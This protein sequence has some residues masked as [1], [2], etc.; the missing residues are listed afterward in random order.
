MTYKTKNTVF[1]FALATLLMVMPLAGSNAFA[2]TG[3]NGEINGSCGIEEPSSINLGSVTSGAQPGHVRIDVI[4]DASIVGTFEI[5]S[6]TDWVGDGAKATG[7][8]LIL[9]S[10][11][12]ATITINNQPLLGGSGT[13]GVGEFDSDGTL[14][15]QATQIAT[16][17]NADTQ[18]I[19][20]VFGTGIEVTAFASG[21]AVLLTAKVAGTGPNAI[22]VV[23]S[24]E[25]VINV[26]D[27]SN[28]MIDGAT[29]ATHYLAEDVHYDIVTDGTAD[30]ADTY[31]TKAELGAIS[32]NVVLTTTTDPDEDNDIQ[33]YFHFSGVNTDATGT[34]TLVAVA[35][36]EQ[37]I[38]GGQTY[39]AEDDG[40]ALAV[41]EFAT[42]AT[43]GDDNNQ[44]AT[45]LAAAINAIVNNPEV[46]ASAGTNVVTI[47]AVKAGFSGNALAFSEAE[48]T[49][50]LDQAG[51]FL[52]G[53]DEKLINLPYSGALSATLT[54]GTACDSS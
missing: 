22:T 17:I 23:S 8:L 11:A 4:T 21:N 29:A 52:T 38:I 5:V 31:A 15:Q 13:T 10:T 32:T 19:A 9:A 40:L 37:I 20:E 34:A 18:V 47:T 41:G 35:D 3:G 6:T 51:G 12:G 36:G 42:E 26:V 25:T 44:D 2:Q 43:P 49:I 27:S 33:V 16:A 30:P 45:N 54:F 14:A 50:T 7:S 39:T 53:G 28:Q 24:S 46:T 1:V 48:S